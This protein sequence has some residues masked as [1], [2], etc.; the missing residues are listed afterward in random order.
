MIGPKCF[1]QNLQAASEDWLSV[2]V[3]PLFLIKPGQVPERGGDIGMLDTVHL[4]EKFHDA[5]E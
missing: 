3:S 4:L 1:F 5:F 2:G